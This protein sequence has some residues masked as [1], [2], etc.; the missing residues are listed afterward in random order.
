M[1]KTATTIQINDKIKQH[2]PN[3]RQ[4]KIQD[5]ELLKNQKIC[6][7]HIPNHSE[8]SSDYEQCKIDVRKKLENCT[9][10]EKKKKDGFVKLLEYLDLEDTKKAIV[11]QM[12]SN[13]LNLKNLL[14]ILRQSNKAVDSVKK[15][16]QF[17][18]NNTIPDEIKLAELLAA[19]DHS[20]DLAA[21]IEKILVFY[22]NNKKEIGEL[23][24]ITFKNLLNAV[25]HSSEPSKHIK[26]I[27][28]FFMY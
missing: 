27:F 17:L 28:D 21:E 23:K 3:K 26:E 25:D 9:D 14:S 7:S 1:S 4:Q 22:T 15:L 8:Y 11:F 19:T 20:Q 12:E 6:N 16:M 2:S 5:K 18:T 13:G 10:K 24:E